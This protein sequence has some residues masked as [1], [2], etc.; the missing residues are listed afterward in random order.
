M[1]LPTNLPRKFWPLLAIL[2]ALF[3]AL[4]AAG[5]WRTLE[6]ATGHAEPGLVIEK[7]VDMVAGEDAIVVNEKYDE[8]WMLLVGKWGIKAV[9]GAAL[10]RSVLVL[11]R[12]R[13]R[14]W[15]FRRVRGH[16]VFAGLGGQNA[17]LA[18]REAR[19]GL[20]VAA[21]VEDEHHPRQ[22]ELEEAGVLVLNGSPGDPQRLGAAGISR[23]SRI[24]VAAAAGDDES[25]AVAE[26]IAATGADDGGR[27][28]ELLVC[29]DSRQ[30]REFLN[31]RWNLIVRPE[32]GWTTKLVGFEAAALRH[33]VTGM[34]RELADLAAGAPPAPR[35]LV[36]A[37]LEFTR[38]FLRAAIPFLQISGE[39]RPEY[40]VVIE[41][42]EEA[43]A[44]ALLHPAAPLVADVR[45]LA[46][47]E[48]LAPVCEELGDL[49]FDV[50]IV[51]QPSE[52]RTLH[53]AEALL[54]SPRFRVR[55]V[56]AIVTHA[57]KTGLGDDPD[58]RVSSLFELGLNSAEFGELTL[59]DEARANHEAYLAGLPP[60]ERAKGGGWRDLPE[61]FKESNRWAVLHRRIKRGIWERT[62][63]AGRQAMLEHLSICEHQR[64]SG[65]KAMDGWRHAELPSQDKKRR[66]HPSII[67]WGDL[68]ESEKEKDRV[69]VRKALGLVE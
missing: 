63:E 58:L 22:G 68:S 8:H 10:F 55:R 39:S 46:V 64:W 9:L 51:K 29:L 50:A 20:V 7:V 1:E 41:D 18:L 48:R 43:G 13:I 30:T 49:E 54:R 56:E 2:F 69:Q 12:R 35:L 61:N 21:L 67:P 66:L 59:E 53:L 11:F 57:V 19:Q 52:S 24:V 26:A 31:Q 33:L 32:R 37:D 25:I 17:D 16:R 15:R 6:E 47:P 34:A 40:R 60:A 5:W 4:G 3:I 44:F 14:V 27:A 45:F 28:G 38:E 65:E 62:P 23:A 42:A 36:V